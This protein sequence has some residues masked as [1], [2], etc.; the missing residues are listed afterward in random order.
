[1]RELRTSGSMAFAL[2]VYV[3]YDIHISHEAESTMA[4]KNKK[5]RK[6][7][8]YKGALLAPSSDANYLYYQGNFSA[9]D[10]HL[11]VLE[12]NAQAL[13]RGDWDRYE[14]VQVSKKEGENGEEH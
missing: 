1:M 8:V 9:L 5:E 11:K 4:K 10:Q 13:I 2:L 14:L 3:L 7:V 12:R 6:P